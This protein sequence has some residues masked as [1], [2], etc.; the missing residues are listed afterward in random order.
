MKIE[1]KLKILKEKLINS[2]DLIEIIQNILQ[3]SKNESRKEYSEGDEKYLFYRQTS[4]ENENYLV[5]CIFRIG[6]VGGSS[7]YDEKNRTSYILLELEKLSA[8]KYKVLGFNN[9]K[10]DKLMLISNG[11][12]TENC[13]NKLKESFKD[14]IFWDVNSICEKLNN[15]WPEYFEGKEPVIHEYLSSLNSHLEDVSKEL[16]ILYYNKTTKTI[17]EIFIDLQLEETK[18]E[19]EKMTFKVEDTLNKNDKSNL[20]VVSN[21][22]INL[23]KLIKKKQK[24]KDILEVGKD[25]IIFGEMGSGKSTILKKIILDLIKE[26]LADDEMKRKNKIP[27]LVLAK[28]FK[29]NFNL[30]KCIEIDMQYLTGNKIFNLDKLLKNGEIIVFIDGFDEIPDENINDYFDEINSFKS[31]YVNVQ[32]IITSRPSILIDKAKVFSEFRRFEILPLDFSQVDEL[33]EKWFPTADK[34]KQKLLNVLKKT[35]LSSAIPKTPLAITLLAIIFEDNDTIEEIPANITELYN[36]FTEIFLGKWDKENGISSQDKYGVRT[37]LINHIA[38]ILQI[39]FTNEIKEKDFEKVLMRYKEDKRYDD[40]HIQEMKKDLLNRNPLFIKEDSKYR[41]IHKSFQEYFASKGI[42]QTNEYTDD[43]EKFLITNFLNEWWANVILFYVGYKKDCPK[44]IE[45]ICNESIPTDVNETYLKIDGLG[46]LLQAAVS[47]DNKSKV[48]GVRSALKS[49]KLFRH[50]IM[51]EASNDISLNAFFRKMKL[52]DFYVIIFLKT[53][54]SIS[55]KSK[56]LK[57]SLEDIYIELQVNKISDLAY[58]SVC[59][60]LTEITKNPQYLLDFSNSNNVNLEWKLLAIKD[61]EKYQK[62]KYIFSKEQKKIIYSVNR[63]IKR[64]YKYLISEFKKL[65]KIPRLK[66]NLQSSNLLEE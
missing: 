1:T 59:F 25:A 43:P 45:R 35:A 10:P 21:Q 60:T 34:H 23:S 20:P 46:K 48:I 13:K 57:P 18:I 3:L 19:T 44:F 58:Y 22:V 49:L 41:F 42:Q 36:K 2:N 17:W 5:M 63:K 6:D 24:T 16:Q 55:F 15:I 27:T 28:N 61:V 4:F 47:T 11:V 64:G 32:I 7:K 33:L 62:E 52:N 51:N 40:V 66:E 31:K 12:F 38:L 65:N 14:I 29:N 30:F 56:H 26:Y 50:F 37:H 39:S 9:S 53:I 54:F 8:N